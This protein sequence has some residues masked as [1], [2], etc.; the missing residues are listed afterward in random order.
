MLVGGCGV[1]V[2]GGAIFGGGVGVGGGG[3]F[4]AGV[5]GGG[6]VGGDKGYKKQSF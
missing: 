1:F 3:G 5:G 2:I 4:G 6:W